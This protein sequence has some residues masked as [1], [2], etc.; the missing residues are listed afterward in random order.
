MDNDLV[1]SASHFVDNLKHLKEVP[2]L[3]SVQKKSQ[4][5]KELVDIELL[6]VNSYNK[7]GFDFAFV[8]DKIILVDL[9]TVKENFY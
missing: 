2:I 3:W 8:D 1:S 7:L 5:I 9:E 4:E 6:L